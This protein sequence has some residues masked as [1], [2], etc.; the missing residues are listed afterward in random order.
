MKKQKRILD[1]LI[2][3]LIKKFNSF[4]NIW[5]PNFSS[6]SFTYCLFSGVFF[7]F[8]VI[9]GNVRTLLEK[10][11]RAH[12]WCTPMDPSDGRAKAG[13]PAGTYIQQL[14]EDTGCSPKDLP[15]AINDEKWRERVRDIRAGGTTWWCWRCL[16]SFKYLDKNTVMWK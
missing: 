12:K 16:N 11:G 8:F 1:I 5:I 2:C 3:L 14:Y 9:Y 15:E 6:S 10:Q 7:F 13:R 4:N